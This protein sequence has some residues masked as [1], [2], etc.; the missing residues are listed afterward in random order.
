MAADASSS[1]DLGSALV[2]VLSFVA[3]TIFVKVIDYFF[4]RQQQTETRAHEEIESV[5]RAV[6]EQLLGMRLQK[7]AAI[8]QQRV[9]ALLKL[10]KYS[11]DAAPLH[12]LL[13]FPESIRYDNLIDAASKNDDEAIRV[14]SF[15]D[16]I[17]KTSGLEGYKT[18]PSVGYVRPLVPKIVWAT[19]SAYETALS[20]SAAQIITAKTGVGGKLLADPKP[21]VEMVRS[22]L[23]HLEKGLTD[24]GASFLAFIVGDLREKLLE[25]ILNA[26]DDPSHDDRESERATIILRKVA[27]VA[28]QQQKQAPTLQK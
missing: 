11:V 18:D 19:F 28:K 1:I 23:P 21:A 27:E 22:V 9:D 13:K 5:R 3:G 7:S 17:W 4:S 6:H 26:L 12:T 15:A 20:H 2:P 14:K 16:A 10:W 24:Y 8:E 25:E